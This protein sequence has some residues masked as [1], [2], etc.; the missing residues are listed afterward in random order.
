MTPLVVETELEVSETV[1]SGLSRDSTDDSADLVLQRD[2]LIPRP[3]R[4]EI[5]TFQVERPELVSHDRLV[6]VLQRLKRN[7]SDQSPSVVNV[8]GSTYVDVGN[9]MQG[10]DHVWLGDVVTGVQ[11]QNQEGDTGN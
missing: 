4:D 11:S 5:R 3:S 7:I 2:V 8:E 1:N 10:T 9:P 6:S